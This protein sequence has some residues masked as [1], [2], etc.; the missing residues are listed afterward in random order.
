MKAKRSI[1]RGAQKCYNEGNLCAGDVVQHHAFNSL[2][3]REI[4]MGDVGGVGGAGGIY[5]PQS[6]DSTQQQIQQLQQQIQLLLQQLQNGTP[7]QNTQ[8]QL[9]NLQQEVN[10]LLNAQPPPDKAT[11]TAL[12]NTTQD[13]DSAYVCT[14]HDNS[15][16]E[17]TSLKSALQALEGL[18]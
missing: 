9:K 7:P 18:N 1:E 17:E 3:Y 2:K 6:Q 14:L 13:L 8:E 10:N 15:F 11:I 12:F 4:I 5:H 16:G